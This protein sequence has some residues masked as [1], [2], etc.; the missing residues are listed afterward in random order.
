MPVSESETADTSSKAG[1]LGLITLIALVVANMIGVGV[2]TSSGYSLATLGNP[3]RVM[4]GWSLCAVWAISGAIAYGG[5]ISR[6]PDSGGEYLFLSR[7][8]HPSAG[9]LAGWISLVAGFSAPIAVSAK[10]AAVHWM[11]DVSSAD[12]QVSL[13]AAAIIV[14]ATITHLAGIRIGT[15]TQN[16]IVATKLCLM[17]WIVIVAFLLT[18]SDKW[19]GKALPDRD[20]AWLPGSL[21]AWWTLAGS[22]SWLALAYTGFNAAIYVAGDSK[23]AKRLVPRAMLLGTLLVAAIYLLLNYIFVFFPDPEKLLGSQG[24]GEEKVAAVAMQELGGAS[25]SNLMRLVIVLSTLSSVW[26]MLMMG[27]R[28][29]RQMSID[30]VFPKIFDDPSYKKTILFQ[31][32]LSVLACF[33]GSIL[34]LMTYLGLTLSAS[35]AMAVSSLLWIRTKLPNSKPLSAI[36]LVAV[37]TYLGLTS[38]LV[39]ATSFQKKSQFWALL[40]TIGIGILVFLAW[41]LKNRKLKSNPT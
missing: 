39:M 33:A 24:F 29:Y 13:F 12:W 40:I 9:F 23:D 27:P 16:L 26:A 5:L 37:S 2:F 32:L 17:A 11:N 22:M 38:I 14:V 36:E 10:N 18:S 28:V 31:C 41:R 25:L 15:G 8:V 1:T 21:E 34:D 30:G 35:G 20:A 7:F 4:L 3:G 19:M 6:L